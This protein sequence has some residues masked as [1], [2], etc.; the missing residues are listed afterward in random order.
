MK[1]FFSQCYQI[2]KKFRIL[3][4]KPWKSLMQN[5]IYCAVQIFRDYY[6]LVFFRDQQTVN[7]IQT[8]DVFLYPLKGFRMLL[9]AIKRDH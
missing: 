7:P 6:N 5:F 1:E 9:G 2:R 3:S 4:H 8:S